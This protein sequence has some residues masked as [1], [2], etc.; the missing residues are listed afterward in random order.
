VEVARRAGAGRAELIADASEIDWSWF[1][2]VA[3]MG[4]SAGASAPEDLVEGVI[5]A[6][7]Q[8]FAAR[9]EEVRIVDE[10]MTF[11]LPRVLGD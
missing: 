8:R 3:A 5:A 6:V 4:L 1:D 9:V 7:S 11:K 2:G 10:H